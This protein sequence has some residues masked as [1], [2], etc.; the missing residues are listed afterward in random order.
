MELV[1]IDVGDFREDRYSRLRS[2]SWWDQERLR[3]ARVM[4]VGAGAIGNEL[5]KNLA[6]LGIGH[7]FIV[8]MDRIENTNLSRSVL[9][10][11]SDEGRQKAE[12]AAEAAIGINPD[13]KAIGFV[14]NVVYDVGLGLF[15]HMD[16]VLGG[17]DN[18]EARLS[19]N[20]SCWKT[21]TPWVDGAIEVVHGFARVFVP[22]QSACYECT[23][24]ELDYKLLNMRRSCTLLS[25]GEMLAGKV[26]TTPTT[27]SVIAGIQVQEAVKLLHQREDL[28]VLAGKGFVFNGLTH[29]SYVVEYPRKDECYSHETFEDIHEL[30]LG[31]AD[32][33]VGEMLQLVRAHGGSSGVVLELDREILC[34]FSCVCG[35]RTSLFKSLSQATHQDAV[36]PDCGEVRA[37][38][39]TH[40]IDGSEN[41]LHLTLEQIGIPPWDIVIGRQGM[42]RQFFELAKD[43]KRVLRDWYEG[44]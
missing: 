2:I 28:P 14:G 18:R 19:I 21:N 12:V 38:E 30:P 32:I 26:P 10:R 27:S 25:R 17:L 20:Q 41:F 31:V 8:D 16:V 4:V 40:T 9:Y 1:S 6:L 34:G 44:D 23:M 7:I 3:D 22:P 5:V 37:P 33:T 24:S 42:N 11:S 36:C 13:I 43:K 29:D 39:L 15:R 35:H